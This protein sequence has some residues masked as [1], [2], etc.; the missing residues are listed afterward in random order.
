MSLCSTSSQS[1]ESESSAAASS[2][3][4]PQ[5][6]TPQHHP[7]GGQSGYYHGMDFQ[8]IIEN[9]SGNGPGKVVHLVAPSMQDKT[10]WISDISQCIDNVH[11]NDFVHSSISD[12]SSVTYPHSVRNDPRLFNDDIDIRFSRTLNSCKVICFIL[13]IEDRLKKYFKFKIFVQVPQIRYATPERLLERLTDLRFL[14]ID[15]LNTFLLTYRVFTDGVTVLD[16]LK[17]VFYAT[18]EQQQQQQMNEAAHH[19]RSS[20]RY[21]CLEFFSLSDSLPHS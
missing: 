15:F 3:G 10:A 1:S 17:K 5:L 9:K 6:K 2:T 11:F 19:N 14:S 12:A 21:K 4:H 13:I 7:I 8:L 20:I 18:A 16:A